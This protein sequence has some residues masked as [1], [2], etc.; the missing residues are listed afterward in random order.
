MPDPPVAERVLHQ[1]PQPGLLEKRT[2]ATIS[3]TSPK[4]TRKSSL[5]GSLPRPP[6]VATAR[7]ERPPVLIQA[8][9]AP[10]AGR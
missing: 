6:Y 10:L 5:P 9:K 3:F 2:P 7:G 4:L 1:F 8:C